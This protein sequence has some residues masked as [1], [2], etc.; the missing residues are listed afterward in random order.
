MRRYFVTLYRNFYFWKQLYRMDRMRK[1][2]E[3]KKV[4]HAFQHWKASDTVFVD[5]EGLD[6]ES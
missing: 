4:A 2:N 5:M 6:I 3:M 1:G